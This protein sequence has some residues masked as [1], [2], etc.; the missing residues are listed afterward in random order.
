MYGPDAVNF[1]TKTMKGKDVPYNARVT[2]AK[3]LLDRG[4]GKPAQATCYKNL[5]ST[6]V[7]LNSPIC[8]PLNSLSVRAVFCGLAAANARG[9]ETWWATWRIRQI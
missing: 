2:A 7:S 1:L 4:Y 9:K 3:E 6:S 8:R 5:S